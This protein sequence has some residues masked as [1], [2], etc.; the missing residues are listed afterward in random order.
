MTFHRA[1]T[2]TLANARPLRLASSNGLGRTTGGNRYSSAFSDYWNIA[3]GGTETTVANYNGTGERWKFHRFN[4]GGTLTVTRG[5]VPFRV[6]G[7]GGAGGGQSSGC[8]GSCSA[9]GQSGETI[10][11]VKAL[12]VGAKTV[13]VGAGGGGGSWS[14]SSNAGAPGGAS[15]LDGVTYRGGQ[16]GIYG[17]FTGGNFAQ[18]STNIQGSGTQSL[19]AICT[20][21]GACGDGHNGPTGQSGFVIVAYRIG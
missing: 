16:G 12:S 7:S 21:A 4:A 6:F 1:S 3:T 14:T 18:L 15:S 10:E 13:T 20:G 2:F 8:C 11:Q 19:G 5:L 9:N 17:W